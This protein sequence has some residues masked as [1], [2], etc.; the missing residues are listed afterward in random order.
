MNSIVFFWSS[1]SIL[2]YIIIFVISIEVIYA[3]FLAIKALK[4][5]LKKNS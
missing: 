1:I 5:Y 2:V 3:L 4:I